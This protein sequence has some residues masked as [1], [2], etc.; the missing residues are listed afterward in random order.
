VQRLDLLLLSPQAARDLDSKR[1]CGSTAYLEQALEGFRR[2]KDIAGQ[3][4]THGCYYLLNSAV[5]FNRGDVAG[6]CQDALRSL[7]IAQD[8]GLLIL[9]AALC[10]TSLVRPQ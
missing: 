8:C 9:R 10:T 6:S 5:L 3:A 4:E 7:A 1:I 2:N